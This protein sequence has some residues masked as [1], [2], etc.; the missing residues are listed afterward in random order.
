MYLTSKQEALLKF[1]EE[2][3]MHHGKSPTVREMREH[4]NVR[5]DNSILK[6]L[7]TLV[8]KGYME[9]DDTPRGIKLLPMVKSKFEM[10]HD[11]VRLPLLGK[12]PA[13]SPT[14]VFAHAEETI[15][16][17]NYFV[18]DEAHSFLLSVKGDSM[19]DAGIFDGDLAIVCSSKQPS[20]GD[21]VVAL[22]DNESTLKRLCKNDNQFYLK[23][24]NKAYKK[25]YPLEGLVVQGVVI[26]LMRRY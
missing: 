18:N 13:G 10:L 26:G 23:P 21:I 5:S 22:I 1:I 4:F 9:K 20:V 3:Q 17:S 14:E 7:K 8:E 6:P 24:E 12:I 11:I 25:L 19:I 15:P 16:M 2:Y